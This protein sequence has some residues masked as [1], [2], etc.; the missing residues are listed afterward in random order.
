M[1]G[2]DNTI[3]A[4]LAEAAGAA[5]YTRNAFRITGVS[6]YADRRTIRQRRRHVIPALEVGADIDLGHD[7]GLNEVRAAFDLLQGDARP[8]LVHELFWLWDT[9][10]ADCSCPR[11]LRRD[12]DQ[13]VRAHSAALEREASA[14]H[15]AG[16]ELDD[17]EKLWSEAGRRWREVLRRAVFWDHVR[18]RAAA[19]DDRQLNESDVDTLRR[20]LPTALVRPLIE[21]AARPGQSQGRLAEVA[22]GWPLVPGKVVDDLL[23]DIVAPVFEDTRTAL[24]DAMQALDADEP[25]RAASTVDERVLPSLRRLEAV[26]PHGRHRRTAGVRNEAA[27]VLNNCATA[28][29]DSQGPAADASARRLLDKASKLSSDPHTLERIEQNRALLKEAVKSFE[30]IEQ[31]ARTF[32]DL[33]RPDLA[34]EVLR[35]VRRALR[36]QP[37]ADDVIDEIAD[38]LRISPPRRPLTAP[39][40]SSTTRRPSAAPRP[41]SPAPRGFFRRLF[42]GV[43]F[44]MWIGVLIG[45]FLLTTEWFGW[46][47]ASTAALFSEVKADNAPV[48]SCVETKE[49]LQADH[50]QVPMID[51]GEPHWGEVL[52]YVSLGKAPSP[53]PGDDQVQSTA[54]FECARLQARQDLIFEEYTTHYLLPSKEAWNDGDGRFENYAPCVL[55]PR[56]GNQIRGKHVVDP[57]PKPEDAAVVPMGLYGKQRKLDPPVGSCVKDKKRWGPEPNNVPIVRCELPHW[58]EIVGYPKLFDKSQP[59]PGDDKVWDAAKAACAK[60]SADLK[61]GKDHRIHI[62][63]PSKDWWGDNK[64]TELY[65]VCLVS[66][67]DNKTFSGGLR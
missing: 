58:A 39:R 36:D 60:T 31:Q 48:G 3:S 50:S 7:L 23:E 17:L 63:W 45:L 10:D 26:V 21:L 27:V 44:L 1:F 64:E 5:L 49:G 8:R 33:G 2:A 38:K 32:V 15:P 6:T 28:L 19:L 54:M 40:R 57:P 65:A 24:S 56:N 34:G 35:K 20:E 61:A 43:K 62:N 13:A 37:W 41:L 30:M 59:W 67:A 11:N 18:H 16:R 9:P 22:R 29:L 12:H 4:A 25:G 55:I 53:Y 14:V 52:G 66:R 51:C 42:R 47:S 46:N